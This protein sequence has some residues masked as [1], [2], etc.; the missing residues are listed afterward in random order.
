MYETT[1]VRIYVFLV[2]RLIPQACNRPDRY[3]ESKERGVKEREKERKRRRES[4]TPRARRTE[5]GGEGWLEEGVGTSLTVQPT[6]YA[7]GPTFRRLL[8]FSLGLSSPL[9]FILS[10]S[11]SPFLSPH[12]ALFHSPAPYLVI[13]SLSVL[14]SGLFPSAGGKHCIYLEF[15]CDPSTR[16]N[17]ESRPSFSISRNLVEHKRRAFRSSVEGGKV[18]WIQCGKNLGFVRVESRR[19][20]RASSGTRSN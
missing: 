11:L 2:R 19:Q 10:F 17:V 14:L 5:E 3:S 16:E 9:S 18:P 4:K 13:R 6:S 12:L 15:L 20:A 7:L 8:S 1:H